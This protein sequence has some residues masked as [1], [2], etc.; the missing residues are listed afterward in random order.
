M[1]RCVLEVAVGGPHASWRLTVSDLAIDVGGELSQ[2][3]RDMRAWA[4]L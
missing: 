2:V 1:G 4:C 3:A